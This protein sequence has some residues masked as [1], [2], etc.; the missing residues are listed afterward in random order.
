MNLKTF[1]L[2]ERL[3]KSCFTL[4]DWPL[5]RVLLKN[6]TEYPWFILVPKRSDIVE[7][8]QF[9]K[10]DRKQLMDEIHQLS[11][12]VEAFFHPDKINIGALGNL[13]A[14]FHFH[15]VGRFKQD[16]LWPQGIWQTNSVETPYQNPE[17]LLIALKK[18]LRDIWGKNTR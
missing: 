8:T 13:V 4:V 5:S 10:A 17:P 12:Q 2:D 11:L 14:Q 9:C 16:P 15:I 7:I 6:C 1:M 3:E 18:Q